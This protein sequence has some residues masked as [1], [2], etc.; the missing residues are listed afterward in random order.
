MTMSVARTIY[1]LCRRPIARVINWG[2]ARKCP[3]CGAGIRRFKPLH[4]AYFTLSA[5][6]GF[7]YNLREFETL[8]VDEYQC[9]VCREADRARLIAVWVGEWVVH[10]IPTSPWRLLDFAPGVGLAHFLR[11]QPGVI[12]RSADMCMAGVDDRVDIARLPYQDGSFDAFICSHV[13]EHVPD[14]RRALSELNRIL[15]P[16]GWGL[17]LVP[18]PLGL[19]RTDEES[20]AE[21]TAPTE[22]T[23]WRRFGQGDHVRLYAR[24]DF[25]RRIHDAGFTCR[26]FCPSARNLSRFGLSSTSVLYVV[27][28][29]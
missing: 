17:L 27:G 18:I 21:T 20:P 24:G 13:L 29:A 25:L 1:E 26:E 9:P 15:A 14:D 19:Q 7:P 23:R 22:V 6:W 16:G 8:H 3:I 5:Q 12:Y 10:R 28:K 11:S 4:K 2:S